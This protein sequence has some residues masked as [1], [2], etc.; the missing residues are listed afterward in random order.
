M[1]YETGT[2]CLSLEKAKTSA[3]CLSLSDLILCHSRQRHTCA[4]CRQ[5]SETWTSCFFWSNWAVSKACTNFDCIICFPTGT[6]V[7]FLICWKHAQPTY[8]PGHYRF[9]QFNDIIYIS[10]LL[11]LCLLFLLLYSNYQSSLQTNFYIV[12]ACGI[13]PLNPGCW[14]EHLYRIF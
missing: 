11:F 13:K 5:W 6:Y 7:D 4:N 3:A 1:Q 10:K 14:I 9:L 2:H 8:A 12:W